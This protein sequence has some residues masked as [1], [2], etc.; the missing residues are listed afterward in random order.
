MEASL[1][2]GG[3]G[4]KAEFDVVEGSHV[5]AQRDDGAAA[6]L[7]WKDVPA[8]LKKACLSAADRLEAAF[9]SCSDA[10]ETVMECYV[11]L[12]NEAARSTDEA[13]GM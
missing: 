11:R 6:Y 3:A 7:E 1:R 9:R 8:E 5:Y 4:D 2:G 10:S 12:E 13:V